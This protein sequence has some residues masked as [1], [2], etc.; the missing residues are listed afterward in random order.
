M[1]WVI[2][3]GTDRNNGTTFLSGPVAVFFPATSI[4]GYYGSVQKNLNPGT[5]Q[6]APGI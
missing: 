4:L 2:E 5:L 3:F 6:I 1:T